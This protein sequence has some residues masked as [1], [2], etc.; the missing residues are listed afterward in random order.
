MTK[1]EQAE[2]R[3]LRRLWMTRRATMKQMLHCMALDRRRKQQ[4]QTN[5]YDSKPS[6]SVT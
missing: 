3:R 5:E 1:K 2:H 4:G 6:S